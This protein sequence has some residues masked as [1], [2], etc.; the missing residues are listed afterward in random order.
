ML[1]CDLSGD[2]RRVEK[3]KVPLHAFDDCLLFAPRGRCD[4]CP[5]KL[6]HLPDDLFYMVVR[7]STRYQNSRS[8]KVLGSTRQD[9]IVVS[10]GPP[11]LVGNEYMVPLE[12]G[13]R[14]SENGYV[15]HVHRNL[16]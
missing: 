8:W 2:V 10:S 7:A 5:Q 11:T 14:F 12:G 6:Q 13:E 15:Q 9:E 1:E 16:A 4:W 3:L